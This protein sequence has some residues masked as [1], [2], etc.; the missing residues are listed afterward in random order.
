MQRNLNYSKD[1]GHTSVPVYAPLK[2]LI[3][4]HYQPFRPPTRHTTGHSDHLLRISVSSAL[5][6]KVTGTGRLR[7]RAFIPHRNHRGDSTICSEKC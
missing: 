2:S 4:V 1:I 6:A 7:P 5:P 3:T